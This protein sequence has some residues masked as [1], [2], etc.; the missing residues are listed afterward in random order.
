MAGQKSCMIKLN[1]YLYDGDTIFHIIQNYARDLELHGSRTGNAIDIDHSN[2]LRHISDVLEHSDFLTSQS[3]R[4]RGFSMGMAA[5]YPSLAFTF[6]GR[7]K[8]LIRAEEKF[9]G[10]IV[11]FIH[12]YYVI[13]GKFPSEE[14]LRDYLKRFHDLI[15]Y[16]IVLSIPKCHLKPGEDKEEAD[17]RYLYKIANELP[18]FME[19]RGFRKEVAKLGDH[20]QNY[21]NS[22][23]LNEDVRKYYRDFVENPQESNYQALH[24]VFYDNLAQCYIEMQLRTKKMDDNAEIGK[25]NHRVYEKQQKLERARRSLIPVGESIYFDE[26][27]ERGMELQHLDLSGLDVDM[28]AALDNHLINDG[29]GL[30]RSRLVLPYEHLSRYQSENYSLLEPTEKLIRKTG[31]GA[32]EFRVLTGTV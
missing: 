9:N 30:Y 17:I 2:F 32:G 29:C 14:E 1:D 23:Q 25:A 27:Y 22:P 10:Y 20:Y 3:E 11:Q 4:I 18:R 13:N 12:D 21:R 7:I 6:K 28:F 8:S 16:R 26:A 24:I 15:A 5:K 19:N 31:V